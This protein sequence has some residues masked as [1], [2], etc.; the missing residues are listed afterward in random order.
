MFLVSCGFQ[1]LHCIGVLSHDS[2]FCGLYDPFFIYRVQNVR[3]IKRPSLVECFLRVCCVC[4]V[5][6]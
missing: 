3:L 6:R 4:Q 5:V 2:L 1:L